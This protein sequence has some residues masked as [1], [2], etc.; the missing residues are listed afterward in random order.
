MS[1]ANYIFYESSRFPLEFSFLK[2]NPAN[3]IKKIDRK[4]KPIKIYWLKAGFG[5]P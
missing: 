3:Y 2:F 1:E 4:H 5:I